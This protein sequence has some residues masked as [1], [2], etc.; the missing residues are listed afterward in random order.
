[1]NLNLVAGLLPGAI[2]V[3][4]QLGVAV[5]PREVPLW[6]GV[7]PGSDG[8][9]DTPVIVVG[10]APDTRAIRNVHRPTLTVHLPSEEKATG[11]GVVIC[12]GGGYNVMEIDK[13]GHEIAKWLNTF[14]IAGFVLKYRLPKPDGFRYKHDIPMRDAQRAMRLVRHHADKWN[15]RRDRIG[16]IGFSAGGHLASTVATHLES[17]EPAAEDPIARY[18]TRPD[19]LIL[20]Y[21]Q[22]S[23]LDDYGNTGT[24]KTLLGA[25]YGPELKRF[26]SNDLHVN[27]QTPPTFLVHANDDPFKPENSAMFYLALRRAGVP[28]ELHIY[29]SGGHGFAIREHWRGEASHAGATWPGHCLEWLRALGMLPPV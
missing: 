11:T 6:P 12:P 13:E 7:A 19:F 5:E 29:G 4:A 3:A 15:V 2:L 20:I 8:A 16:M 24:P 23:F 17:G 22:V 18:P 28:A 27:E 14:G 25:D 26:Y 10:G 21:A 9:P 1:M